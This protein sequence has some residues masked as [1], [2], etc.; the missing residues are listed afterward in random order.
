MVLKHGHLRL[1]LVGVSQGSSV[2]G[3]HPSAS[4]V[5]AVRPSPRLRSNV[6]LPFSAFQK[7][8]WRRKRSPGLNLTHLCASTRMSLRGNCLSFLCKR[9]LDAD[10]LK[11]TA[12]GSCYRCCQCPRTLLLK[13]KCFRITDVTGV[14]SVYWDC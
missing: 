8:F 12:V 6:P 13:N 14:R 10:D 11:S 2:P 7:S 9:S 5:T 3:V 4:H 1:K